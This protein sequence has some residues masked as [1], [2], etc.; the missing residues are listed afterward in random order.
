MIEED[1]QPKLVLESVVDRLPWPLAR[2][3]F[4]ASDLPTSTGGKASVQAVLELYATQPAI[5]F[6]KIQKLNDWLKEAV[7]CGSCLVTFFRCSASAKK[8]ILRGLESALDSA[9]LV[10]SQYPL[11]GDSGDIDVSNIVAVEKF[12]S[13]V[14]YIFETRRRFYQTTEI[15]ATS[16]KDEVQALYP[17]L[18]TLK[19]FKEITRVFYDSIFV[20]SDG[21]TL[22]VRMDTSGGMNGT[23]L[24]SARR[25]FITTLE[26]Y[27]PNLFPRK[28]FS[29]PINLFPLVD[30]V[31][32]DKKDGDLV[33]M[34]FVTNT[35]FVRSAKRKKGLTDLRKERYHSAGVKAEKLILNPYKVANEYKVQMA[36]FV[37]TQPKMVL[38]GKYEMYRKSSIHLHYLFI[39]RALGHKDCEYVLARIRRRLALN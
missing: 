35:G 20:T 2:L 11:L 9:T 13:G 36:K 24:D 16:L 39:Q 28:F 7:A 34:Q 18:E 3:A 23:D 8:K 21:D 6:P 33:E 17:H 10:E 32:S 31:Y 19:G 29:S 4:I 14:S 27:A 5:V 30:Q 22:E 15:P 25:N 1:L 26:K 12:D 38:P 37:V